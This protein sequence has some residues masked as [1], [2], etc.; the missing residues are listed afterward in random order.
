[1]SQ[2]EQVD[3]RI[4]RTHRFLQE[5]LIELITER[6]FEAITVSDIAGRAMINRATF[7]R[8]YQ[9]KYDL[10]AKIFE[11]AAN[12]LVAQMA[13]I[14]KDA[15]GVVTQTPEIWVQVFEHVAK[16]ANLYRALLGDKGSSWFAA[17]MREHTVKIMREQEKSW[18]HRLVH[19][20]PL[21]PAFPLD[22]PAT[23]LA[24][25]LIGTISWWLASDK[26][27]TPGQMAAWFYRFAFSGYL[28]ALGYTS[29]APVQEVK[30]TDGYRG[31]DSGHRPAQAALRRGP[32]RE[33]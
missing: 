23:Q 18:E 14:H 22:L 26:Q 13:P 5:A 27:Y 20:Q 33:A 15:R 4:R 21:G 3:L 10:V 25:V 11:E 32:L 28:S 30:D 24:H 29:P 6:G 17:K 8:H 19:E 31:D 7:Y 1:M 9:D 2:N 16:H 12:E